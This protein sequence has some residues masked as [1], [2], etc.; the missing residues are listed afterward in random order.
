MQ[1]DFGEWLRF[2]HLKN[3]ELRIVFSSDLDNLCQQRPIFLTFHPNLR[4]RNYVE[5]WKSR[6]DAF[7]LSQLASAIR[8]GNHFNWWIVWLMK[9]EKV[10]WENE[11][12]ISG[13]R[14]TLHILDEISPHLKKILMEAAGLITIVTGSACGKKFQVYIF[15]SSNLHFSCVIM[16]SFIL[17]LI[18]EENK[19]LLS[20]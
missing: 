15:N 4:K 11:V 14:I 3:Q 12:H 8:K 17:H 16:V 10:Y 1:R 5:T 18:R 7:L 20:W 2:G 9:V 13:R 6:W 19:H